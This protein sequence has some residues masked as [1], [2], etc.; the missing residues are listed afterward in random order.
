[1]SDSGNKIVKIAKGELGLTD[2]M[3]ANK[4]HPEQQ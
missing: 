1:M 4:N 3:G 2:D